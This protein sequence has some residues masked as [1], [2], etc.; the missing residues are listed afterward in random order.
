ML[1][2][3]GDAWLSEMV[4]PHETNNWSGFK[5]NKHVTNVFLLKKG[6]IKWNEMNLRENTC[7]WCVCVCDKNHH[8]FQSPIFAVVWDT[9]R[10]FFM[11]IA[12]KLPQKSY[13]I[14]PAPF[15]EPQRHIEFDQHRP[16]F[17]TTSCFVLFPHMFFPNSE[18][19]GS[20]DFDDGG[21]AML[22]FARL[23]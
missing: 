13:E 23:G 20:F 18:T 1:G 9:V 15:E 2:P 8:K 11:F 10:F 19:F 7:V 5:G 17:C 3:V 21:S 12:K 4:P 6:I 16:G 22:L 14:P